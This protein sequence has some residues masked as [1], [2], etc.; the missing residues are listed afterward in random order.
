MKRNIA[1]LFTFLGFWLFAK[2]DH[3]TGGE[4]FYTLLGISEGQYT[5]RVTAKLFKD[6]HR[7]RQFPSPAIISVF[8]KSNNT[9]VRDISV[10]LSNSGRLGLTNPNKCITNPPDVCYDIAYYTFDISLPGSANG[11]LIVAQ[12]VFRVNGISNLNSGYGN[13]GAT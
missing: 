2:A 12:I 3:I 5:Y 8:D 1:C 10:P 11:Y 9:R 13:V 7:N 6:C 4:M